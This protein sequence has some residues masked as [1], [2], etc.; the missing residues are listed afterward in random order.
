MVADMNSKLDSIAVVV[1]PGT[2]VVGPADCT[3]FHCM[4]DSVH[5]SVAVVVAV[6]FVSAAV[7]LVSVVVAES[8]RHTGTHLVLVVSPHRC[9]PLAQL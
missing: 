4:G 5:R 2:P 3:Y 7:V 1:I 9:L 8:D 6:A